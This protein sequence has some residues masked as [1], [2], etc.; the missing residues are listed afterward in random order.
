M[1]RETELRSLGYNLVTKWEHEFKNEMIQNTDIREFVNQ[2]DVQDR[3]DP[4]NSF[5]GGRTNAMKL[6]YQVNNGETI[7]YYDFTSLYPFTNKYCRYPIGHPTIITDNFSDISNYFGIAKIKVLAPRGLYHPVLPLRSNGK[8]KF[9]LCKLCADNE[10]QAECNCNDEQRSM[11]GTWCTPEIQT[12]VRKGYKVLKIYEVYN[13]EESTQ[14]N[15][16]TGDGGL[17]TQY[18]NMFLKIKQ[19]ASGFPSECTTEG[20]KWMYIKQYKLKEGIDLDYDK[21]KV[22]KGLRNLAKL[23]LNSFW[24]K[25]GQRLRFKQS[26]FIHESEV[27]ILFKMLT[28]PRKEVNDFHIVAKDMIQLE[29]C[30][31]PVFLPFDT[32]TNIFLASFTT[33]WARLRLYS[34]LDLLDRDVLYF[35]TDSVI[36][37]CCGNEKLQKLPIGNYLGELTN[38]VNSQDHIVTFCSGGPKNYAYKTFL[39]KEECKV[40]GFTLNW[41]NSKLINFRNVES[42]INGSGLQEITVTNPCKISRDARKRKLY[43]RVEHKIYK[44]VYTKRRV[45]PNLDT[46]P[47]GF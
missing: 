36:F 39:G 31:D 5:F 17:F 37:R 6:H 7:Q 16:E 47:F 38:E 2:L 3:L 40:R 27:E 24:G 20:E 33:M 12:A 22:N 19:E 15:P 13:F 10:N 35:D 46:E 9:P 32:K 4:R 11:I 43:N 34:V 28:D 45:L 1:K 44:T 30:D 14:Y 23:C 42:M 29:W 21:I 41:T 26:Q 8:L 18:V 25:F